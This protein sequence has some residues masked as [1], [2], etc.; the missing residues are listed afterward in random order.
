MKSKFEKI[1]GLFLSGAILV[2]V[3]FSFFW[4]LYGFVKGEKSIGGMAGGYGNPL[5]YDDAR[6]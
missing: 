4:Q 3:L 2:L 1:L 6:Y 5:I